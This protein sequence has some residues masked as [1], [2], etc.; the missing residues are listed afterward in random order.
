MVA[1]PETSRENTKR[2]AED[3]VEER[4]GEETGKVKKLRTDEPHANGDEGEEYPDEASNEEKDNGANNATAE[5]GEDDELATCDYL[6]LTDA[7]GKEY[8]VKRLRH[9]AKIPKLS[10]VGAGDADDD[11]LD[12]FYAHPSL[13]LIMRIAILKERLV[14]GEN[15][16]FE[17]IRNEFE[18]PSNVGGWVVTLWKN[19]DKE[20]RVSLAE[21]RSLDP[22]GVLKRLHMLGV[23]HGKLSPT[24]IL[25]SKDDVRPLFCDFKHATILNKVSEK[26]AEELKKKDEDEL[27]RLLE[28]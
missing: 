3:D 1:A 11:R 14:R 9:S 18:A 6:D 17:D 2:A 5:K 22:L 28:A 26:E 8:R 23:A 13:P 25:I 19:A 21:P 16:E 12:H 20:A 4:V 24:S 10:F 7:Y 15:K 27:K